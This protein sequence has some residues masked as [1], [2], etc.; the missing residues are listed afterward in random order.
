MRLHLPHAPLRLLGDRHRPRRLLPRLARVLL[1]Q[2]K[3]L[4]HPLHPLQHL[5][6][7]LRRQLR[8]H[9]QRVEPHRD[10]PLHCS[11]LAACLRRQREPH[12]RR[13]PWPHYPREPRPIAHRA[14]VVTGLDGPSHLQRNLPQVRAP[15]P[16]VLL[17]LG[18]GGLAL[19]LCVQVRHHHEN[20][21]GLEVIRGHEHPVAQRHHRP[22]E[23][24][25]RPELAPEK[26]RLV[27]LAGLVP[28]APRAHLAERLALLAALQ[29]LAEE[30]T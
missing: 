22:V 16:Q 3:P 9:R 29:H 15:V 5:G 14:Q 17:V 10:H 21:G 11:D 24:G 1:E 7:L 12:H 27:A 30:V 2:R 28:H 4:A 20:V 23:E 13:L 26:V 6:V 18:R 8:W 25:P 19:P